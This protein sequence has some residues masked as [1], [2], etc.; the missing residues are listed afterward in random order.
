[1]HVSLG[2]QSISKQESAGP[3][4]SVVVGVVAALLILLVVFGGALF[5]SLMPLVTAGVALVVATSLID[6]LTH[7]MNV[8][9]A[10]RP[11]SRS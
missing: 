7:T 1:M 4:L 8:A 3:G 11:I 10:C 5:A 6:L 2:G 9:R